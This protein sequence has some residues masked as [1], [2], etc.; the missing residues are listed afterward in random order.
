MIGSEPEIF[1]YSHRRSATGY[2]CTYPL[3]EPQP[4]AAAM[5]TEMIRE[6]EKSR[7]EYVVYVNVRSS[8]VQ[9]TAPI[10]HAIFDWFDRYHREQLRLVGLVEIPP[11]GQTQY[12]WFDQPETNV[13]TSAE[14]WLAIFKRRADDAKPER[15]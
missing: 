3:V 5:Q 8:W 9:S 6:V 2:I 11:D 7:P 1:F 12:Q 15:N 4:Y 13:Q 14:S 10:S